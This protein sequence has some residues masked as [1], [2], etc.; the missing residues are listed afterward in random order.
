MGSRTTPRKSDRFATSDDSRPRIDDR[1]LAG[2]RNAGI[3]LA[4]TPPLSAAVCNSHAEL[5]PQ[6]P[7]ICPAANR[8]DLSSRGIVVTTAKIAACNGLRAR[9]EEQLAKKVCQVFD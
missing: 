7:E 8:T 2:N 9:R 4:W 1:S 6:G 5:G 3:L